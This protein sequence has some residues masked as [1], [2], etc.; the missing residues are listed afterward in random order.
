M[1]KVKQQRRRD[2][3]RGDAAVPPPPAL[4]SVTSVTASGASQVTVL[5][6]QPVIIMP[7]NLPT[8][9]LFGTSNRTIT[10]LVSMTPTSYVFT[11]SGSVAAAQAY[12][13]AGSDPAARTTTGGYIAAK[14]GTMA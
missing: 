9:W 8:T 11:V 5:F 2:R 10:A 4:G 13:I 6:G 14:N 3:K 12:A 1:I 7:E